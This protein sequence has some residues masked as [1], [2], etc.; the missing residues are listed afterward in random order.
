MKKNAVLS[1]L[2]KIPNSSYPVFISQIT[3]FSILFS[4]NWS[5][6]CTL[7]LRRSWKQV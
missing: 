3:C 7:V 5:R 6:Q 4:F 2:H 1:N